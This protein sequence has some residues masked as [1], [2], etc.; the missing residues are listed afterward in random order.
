MVYVVFSCMELKTK[1]SAILHILPVV[2]L[3][4]ISKEYPLSNGLD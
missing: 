2:P 3:P 4:F 1:I